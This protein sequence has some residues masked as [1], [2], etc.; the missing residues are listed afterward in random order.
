MGLVA[1]FGIRARKS[2]AGRAIHRF[3]NQFIAVSDLRDE[4]RSIAVLPVRWQISRVTQCL[5]HLLIRK[6]VEEPRLPQLDRK[7]LIESVSS[8]VVSPVLLA[9][10]ARTMLSFSVNGAA[11][12]ERQ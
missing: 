3:E 7:R 10:A 12:R 9:K 1:G 2:V 11:R 5:I 6:N 8:K 4:P